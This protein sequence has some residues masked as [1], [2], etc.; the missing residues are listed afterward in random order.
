MLHGQALASK[1]LPKSLQK[2]LD[3]IIKIVNFIKAR[4]LNSRLFRAF[5]AKMDL[6]HQVFLL[7]HCDL[8]AIP[9]QCHAKI[10]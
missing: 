3:Q 4:A 5:C 9:R 2:V 8:I 7:L 6:D 1:T 10:L